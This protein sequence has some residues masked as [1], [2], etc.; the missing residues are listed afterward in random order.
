MY[1]KPSLGPGAG[2]LSVNSDV[3]AVVRRA[4]VRIRLRVVVLLEAGDRE[5]SSGSAKSGEAS[6]RQERPVLVERRL[7]GGDRGSVLNGGHNG[8]R[9]GVGHG[10]SFRLGMVHY[11][12]CISCELMTNEA[13]NSHVLALQQSQ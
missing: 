7:G 1:A 2:G 9:V 8:D 12:P 11:G 3:V 5:R 4:L 13:C 6:T 10:R